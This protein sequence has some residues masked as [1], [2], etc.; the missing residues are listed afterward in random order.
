MKPRV[1]LLSFAALA[2]LAGGFTLPSG[3]PPDGTGLREAE[4]PIVVEVSPIVIAGPDHEPDPEV[5]EAMEAH[6][7]E[8]RA[9]RQAQSDLPLGFPGVFAAASGGMSVSY[10]SGY[11]A[12]SSVTAVVDAAVAQWDSVIATNPAGPIVVEVF[13]SDLGN[14]SL[15]GYAG[16]DGMFH[17]GGLPSNALYPSALTNTLLGLDANG[18]SRPEIQVVLNS[19]LLN[20]NHWYLGTTGAPPSGQIDLYSVVLHEVG[21]GLGFLGSATIPS[22]QSQ[23]SLNGTPYVY[24]TLAS[25]GATPITSVGDQGQALRSGDVHAEISDGLSYELYAPGSWVSGSSFSHFDEQQYPGG[26][27]GALMTPMLGGAESARIL[28]SPTLG[29]MAQMGWPLTVA[30]TTPTITS[31]SPSLTAAVLSW[32][33]NLWQTGTAPNQYVVEA[34]R[35]GTTLQSSLTVDGGA[36]GAVI[37]SLSPGANYTIKVIPTGANGAGTATTAQVALPTSGGPADPSEWPTY[38][39]D[40]AL[41]GQIN[42]LYQ[43]YFLRLADQGG[44]DYWLGQRSQGTDLV[45]ISA[46]FAGSA[47]FQ[48]RYGALSDGTFVDL[49]YA[50]VLGRV[51]DDGGRT[52][53]LTQLQQGV[54]RGEV[55]IGFAESAEYIDRTQTAPATDTAEA[56]VVRLYRAFFLRDPDADGLAYWA[57]QLRVGVPLETVAGAFAQSAEFQA[58]YGQLSDPAFVDLVYGNVL[59][60]QPDGGG[61][62]YWSGLLA[63]GTPR[64]TVMVGFSESP[65]FVR[66]TGTLP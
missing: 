30:A 41:D 27:A 2:L 52:Y 39:R 46:A 31:A 4:S 60:R 15:L 36:T 38:I 43:A 13:W 63:A 14:P 19:Q 8:L 24:D 3:T 62:A 12:P 53:W 49:V 42:R 58:R 51:A 6:V 1:A 44:F 66:S 54:S 18:G 28:D 64:G 35:D 23:P 50:N 47:E 5:Q 56:R 40:T 37:G 16:P 20:S 9:Q 21:H 55:M 29:L 32:D 57:G 10:N 22:G 7:A 26:T 59:G 17:G 34:W 61:A 25:H 65:E 11:P 33:Q 48:N 45:D